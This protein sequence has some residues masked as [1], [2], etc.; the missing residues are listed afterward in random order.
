MRNIHNCNVIEYRVAVVQVTSDRGI[1]HYHYRFVAEIPTDCML[2][3]EM[4]V[5]HATN[6]DSMSEH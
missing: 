4:V 2:F 5:M 3:L 6:I 1:S